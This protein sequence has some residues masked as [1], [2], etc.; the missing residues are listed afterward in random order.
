MT[1]TTSYVVNL[2]EAVDPRQVGRK[3]ATLARLRRDGFPVPDGVVLICE[4]LEDA[5]AEAGLPADAPADAVATIEVPPAITSGL[6]AAVRRWDGAPLAV[7]SSGV[8]EDLAVNVVRR[9]VYNRPRCDRRE[10]AAGGGSAVLGLGVQRAGHVVPDEI[11]RTVPPA[12]GPG[13]AN[14]PRHGG[15]CGVY[16]RPGNRRAGR[17]AGR[18]RTRAGRAIG[19]RRRRPR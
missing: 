19:F 3:A 1:T 8:E 4:A 11:R 2:R 12:G 9:S 14:G 16:R 18:G 10:P 5:L 6:R 7:R 15:R 17:G 13:A